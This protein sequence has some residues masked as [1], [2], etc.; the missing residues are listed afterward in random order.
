MSFSDHQPLEAG[1]KLSAIFW[2]PNEA[3]QMHAGKGN[4]KSITVVVVPGGL[5]YAY[6]AKSEHEGKPD[7]LHNLAH[8]ET[9]VLLDGADGP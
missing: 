4:C 2:P 3:S 7:Q 6:W 1:T 9:V 8:V 5:G